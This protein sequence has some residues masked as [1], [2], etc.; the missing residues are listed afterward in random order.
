[1]T[2]ERS[3][4]DMVIHNKAIQIVLEEAEVIELHRV[5]IDGDEASALG[6]LRRHLG[7]VALRLLEG[8]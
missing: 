6:W 1:M 4:G 3:G 7:G 8:G 5:L 2:T